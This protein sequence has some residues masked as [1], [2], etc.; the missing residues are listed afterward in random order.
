MRKEKRHEECFENGCRC[1]EDDGVRYRV[2]PLT[3]NARYLAV[4]IEGGLSFRYV[5]P[6]TA[7]G[8]ETWLSGVGG[9]DR[10]SDHRCPCGVLHEGNIQ[11]MQ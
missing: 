1:N 7:V 5:I 10:H 11:P 2:L 3:F 8:T 4:L 6:W 9:E